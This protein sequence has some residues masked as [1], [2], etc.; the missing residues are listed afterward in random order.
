[1]QRH[2]ANRARERNL[3]YLVRTFAG[4][5]NPKDARNADTDGTMTRGCEPAA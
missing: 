1:M 3:H 2:A 4:L 5:K